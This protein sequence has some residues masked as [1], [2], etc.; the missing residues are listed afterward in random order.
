VLIGGAAVGIA[1]WLASSEPLV[2]T[3]C[4]ILADLAG[5]ALMLPKTWRDPHSETL[6]TFLLA[7][8]AG[9]LSATAVGALELN[10]L[11]YPA[12]FAVVNAIIAAVIMLRRRAERAPWRSAAPARN[13]ARRTPARVRPARRCSPP[14]VVAPASDRF[15]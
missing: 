11:L 7:A 4:V 9:C 8:A 13:S 15:R 10:L 5:A 12:Y 6:S 2:A 3:A 1:G 14:P